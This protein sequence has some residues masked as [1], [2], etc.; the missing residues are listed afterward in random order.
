[1]VPGLHQR[2]HDIVTVTVPWNSI[3]FWA[4]VKRSA[5][6]VIECVRL[7]LGRLMGESEVKRCLTLTRISPP[8]HSLIHSF[9]HALIGSP[10]TIL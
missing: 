10:P 7:S 6:R 1:M 4:V 9:A 3:E 8:S 5:T 2:L